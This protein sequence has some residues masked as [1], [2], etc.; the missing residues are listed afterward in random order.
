MDGNLVECSNTFGANSSSLGVNDV[1]HYRTVGSTCHK[2]QTGGHLTETGVTRGVVV[3]IQLERTGD[4]SSSTARTGWG[5]SNHAGICHH[6]TT[7]R[8][9]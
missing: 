5:V 9:R 6:I 8:R 4:R 7:N 3:L 2:C 1:K